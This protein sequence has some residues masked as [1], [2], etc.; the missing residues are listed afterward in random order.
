MVELNHLDVG[1]VLH[2]RLMYGGRDHERR[3]GSYMRLYDGH[4]RLVKDS[5]AHEYWIAT[6]VKLIKLFLEIISLL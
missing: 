4:L 5:I 2:D 1:P 6:T 3:R